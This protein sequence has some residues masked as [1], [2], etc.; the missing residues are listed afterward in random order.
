MWKSPFNRRG[1]DRLVRGVQPQRR[2]RGFTYLDFLIATL[3]L[4]LAASIAAPRFVQTIHRNRAE[5][6][7]RR[8]KADLGYARQHAI[9]QSSPVT[10]QFFPASETYTIPALPDL[11]RVGQTYSVDLTVYPY[12]VDIVS[13]T[14]GGDSDVQFDRYG[15]PDSSGTI[16]VAAGTHQQTVTID[17]DSGR[18]TIP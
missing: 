7:A 10:V 14:L 9:S 11:D 4:G 12:E 3:L 5:M 16:T 13:A 1:A 2:R 17:P 15:Q 6:A 8:I 18:A